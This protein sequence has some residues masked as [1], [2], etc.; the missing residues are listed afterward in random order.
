MSNKSKVLLVVVV[1]V[2]FLGLAAA[3]VL[4][5]PIFGGPIEGERLERMRLSSHYVDGRFEN[6]PPYQAELALMQNLRD[7]LGGQ[8]REP[9]FTIPVLPLAPGA[10]SLP[11]LAGMRAIW[12]GHSTVLIEIDGV[13]ILTDPVLSERA[14][15]FQ[16]IGP[17]RMH[18]PPIELARLGGIDAAVISH[19]H[20][21]HLDRDTVLQLA[22]GGTHFFVGLGIGA[23]LQRWSVP[24]AQIHE[25]DWWDHQRFKGVEIHS[26]P[27]RHYSGRKSMDNPTLWSS[28]MIRGAGYSVYYSGDTG[29][30]PHFQ[31]IRQRLGA[32]DLTLM[33]IGAYGNSWVDIHMDPESAV[34]AHLD[35]GARLMLPVHW[36]T[37]NLSY[38]AWDEP[39]VRA[40]AA[41]RDKGA[42]LVTPRVGELVDGDVPFASQPWYLPPTSR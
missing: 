21:D 9:G 35:L 24:A 10:L 2:G 41:A 16:F 22:R 39:I 25:M 29:Y 4:S 12:F 18:P 42:Q 40:M 30:G 7:Y 8:Q 27:A 1:V 13:R 28:W 32:P 33:K 14:S 37:F 3:L 36:A 11:P 17:G 23:H 6:S 15:P 31:Q 38:H 34:Q 20:Y 26:A 5:L 19:D